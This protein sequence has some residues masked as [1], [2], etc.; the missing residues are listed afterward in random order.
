[1]EESEEAGDINVHSLKSENVFAVHSVKAEIIL[2]IS[3]SL[4]DHV[5]IL[6]VKK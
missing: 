5:Q 2:Y 3:C 1:M 4:T 6:V